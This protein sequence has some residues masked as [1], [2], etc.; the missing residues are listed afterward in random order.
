MSTTFNTAGFIASTLEKAKRRL[1]ATIE[2]IRDEAIRLAPVDTGLLQA[3]IYSEI[4]DNG[5]R[6]RVGSIASYTIFVEFGTRLWSGQPFLRPALME[7]KRFWGGHYNPQLHM[8]AV[9][10]RAHKEKAP[11][12]PLK[13]TSI[14]GTLDPGKVNWGQVKARKERNKAFGQAMPNVGVTYHGA[15]STARTAAIPKGALPFKS[16]RNRKSGHITW[17]AD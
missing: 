17:T 1:A 11:G 10:S 8:G 7:T 5:M 9:I 14:P 4:L 13:A 12:G 16:K 2:A 6:G 15:R 3:G